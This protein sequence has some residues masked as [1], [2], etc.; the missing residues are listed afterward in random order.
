MAWFDTADDILATLS[1]DSVAANPIWSVDGAVEL[2]FLGGMRTELAEP[3]TAMEDPNGYAAIRVIG[4]PAATEFVIAP[5]DTDGE[6]VETTDELLTILD[7]GGAEVTEIDAA[8]IDG[9][10]ARVFDFGSVSQQTLLFRAVDSEAPWR[11]PPRGRL[12]VVEHPER[13]LV[14][15]TAEAYVDP[16]NAFPLALAQTEPIIDSLEFID[17]G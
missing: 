9:I 13:G 3:A 5:T 4:Q 16:D 2:P 12:W 1:F 8:E 17:L 6:S 15:I 14:L 11:P 10:E 7:E